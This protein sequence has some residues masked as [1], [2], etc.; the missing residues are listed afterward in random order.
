FFRTFPVKA[1]SRM[2]ADNRLEG[3][4]SEHHAGDAP[5]RDRARSRRG[6]AAFR[7]FRGWA[8]GRGRSGGGRRGHPCRRGRAAV[9]PVRMAREEAPGISLGG[10]DRVSDAAAGLAGGILR[11]RRESA[12]RP[13]AISEFLLR[14][15]GAVSRV[16][17]ERME[18]D[19]APTWRRSDDVV[20]RDL[21]DDGRLLAAWRTRLHRRSL[22][23]S[24]AEPAHAGVARR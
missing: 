24:G 21:S 7:L 4:R 17:M 14:L 23:D 18:D 13:Q 3:A 9:T 16:R 10:M 2:D 11:R 19:P 1:A 22:A 8:I 12:A 20:M 5:F 6:C 15:P